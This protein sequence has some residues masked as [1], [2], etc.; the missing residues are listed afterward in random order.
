MVLGI[1]GAIGSGKST[2][3][4]LITREYGFEMIGTDQ[5]A[6]KIMTEDPECRRELTEAFGPE[7]YTSCGTIDKDRYRELIHKS[8][9]NR[10]RS[11]SIIH[12][13]VWKRIRE[14]VAEDP[15][16]NFL[17][18]TAL[19]DENFAGICDNVILVTADPC[20]RAERLMRDRGYS[21]AYAETVIANQK[22][23]EEFRKF[24]TLTVDNSLGQKE[25]A[26]NI[27]KAV[28]SL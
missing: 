24:A 8:A 19:P 10:I 1:T 5:L 21:K 6:N 16:G 23:E 3:A 17:V 20:V 15:S 26:Q 12:P 13:R 14:I 11:D 9:E 7:I 27:R 22:S 4:D 18:E 2:A 25:L 28:E